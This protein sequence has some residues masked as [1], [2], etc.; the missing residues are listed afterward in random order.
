MSCAMAG[1]DSARIRRTRP[2]GF[3]LIELLV[4]LA[5]MMITAA[6][7]IPLV[8]SAIAQFKMNS[9][10][11]SMT[12]IIQA[13]RYRAISSGYP[14]RVAFS[15]ANLTY[16]VQS[17]PNSNGAFAN[18]GNAVPFASASINPVLNADITLQFR[19]NG[20]VSTVAGAQ[21]MTLTLN[22]RTKTITVGN[23]GNINITPP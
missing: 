9:A 16:Q 6:I 23:Y 18:V 19:P 15:T 8:S 1:A 20:I 2:F 3:S 7:A 10:A 21:P 13:T 11:L 4:T 22:N 14:Y 17:D 5:I 12:G